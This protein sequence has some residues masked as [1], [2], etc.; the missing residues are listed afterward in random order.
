M[1]EPPEAAFASNLTRWRALPPNT[2]QV[3]QGYVSEAVFRAQQALDAYDSNKARER[4]DLAR[5]RLRLVSSQGG[6]DV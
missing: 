5:S 3:L 1:R 2:Q 4:K 6:R